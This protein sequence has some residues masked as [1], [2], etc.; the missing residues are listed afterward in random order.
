MAISETSSKKPSQERVWTKYYI[1][2]QY[3]DIDPHCT[4]YQYLKRCFRR[5]PSSIAIEYYGTHVSY[6]KFFREIDVLADSF[7]AIGIGK[8][9]KVVFL[10][11]NTPES[12]AA[13]Y[14]LNKIG[15]IP[16]NVEP[17]MGFER[18]RLFVKMVQAKALLLLDIA[19][20]KIRDLLEEY[21]LPCVIVM[22]ANTPLPF[23]KR[24]YK[25]LTD[26]KPVIPYDDKIITFADFRSRHAQGHAVEVDYEE[27][28]I[29]SISQTGGTTGVPKGV[30]LTNVGINT[31]AMNF[32]YL[33]GHAGPV[34]KFLDIMPLF[35]S[36]GVVCGMHAPLTLGCINIL[37]P[38]FKPDN[39]AK[40]VKKYKPYCV[41]AVPSF[42]EKWLHSPELEGVDLSNLNLAIS[43]GDCM[44]A[45]LENHLNEFMKAHHSSAPILQG[46]GLTETSSVVTLSFGEASKFGS[47]GVPLF[48]AT[49]GIFKPGTTEELDYGEVGEIC[50]SGDTIMKGYYENE[51][52]TAGV[53]IRHPD[54]R[55]WVHS[56][57]LGSIERD[58]FLNFR[59]RTKYVI[60]RW[61]GHKLFPS[62]IENVVDR[63]PE[64]ALSS[65]IS[66]KD[67]DHSH[68]RLPLVVILKEARYPITD[69]ELREKTLRLCSEILEERGQPCGVVFVDEMPLTLG[70]KVD[71]KELEGR[72]ADYDY[73]KEEL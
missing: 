56:G 64:V 51:S 17:R 45:D 67:L 39:F 43:G 42:F 72:F 5:D 3:N 20:P 8:G 73:R 40:L 49:L 26:K 60:P 29:C 41:I 63:Q 66:I 1:E 2:H 6:E 50:V 36:Y 35:T 21:P 34:R 4:A 62:Q 46:F 9:D 22:N 65:V 30:M 58:G 7:A 31:V 15:A 25:N 11:V 55:L 47:V 69:K 23:V 33:P 24:I 53:L 59:G 37:V 68:G 70:G 28:S 48:S 14:A 57:D 32:S 19:Y 54:G 18:I 71:K 52:E 13:Y 38:D 12:F 44:N 61:D 27:G 10:T 16:V